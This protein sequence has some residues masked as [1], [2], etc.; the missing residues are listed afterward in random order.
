M[1][2]NDAAEAVAQME[3]DAKRRPRARSLQPLRA[4]IPLSADIRAASL[5][6]FLALL[7]ATAATLAMPIAVR[8]MIDN[9]FSTEDANSIDR[10]FLPCWWSPLFW[11]WPAPCA[12]I[13]SH[14]LAKG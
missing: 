5:A 12:F 7:A 2:R 13:S 9:G 8:F 3:E 10:Y 6:A 1:S 4:L 11:V 14:G